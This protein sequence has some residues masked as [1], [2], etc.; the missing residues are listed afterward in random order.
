MERKA[1]IPRGVAPGWS[2]S[3]QLARQP[4]RRLQ[5]KHGRVMVDSNSQLSSSGSWAST[6]PDLEAEIAQAEADPSRHLGRYRLLSV[7]GQGG[8]GVVHRAWDPTLHRLVAIKHMLIGQSADP[9]GVSR[10]L[11]EARASGRLSH[12]SIVS[13]LG[14]GEHRGE[15]FI[16]M[17][18]LE[19][20]PLGH[21]RHAGQC[22]GVLCR[23]VGR[24]AWW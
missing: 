2:P 16:V 21:L 24:P 12:P 17:E 20:Q 7:L 23:L 13:I 9:V 19:G 1:N 18:L 11:R 15:P 22:A 4:L 8:M 14:L 5:V 3:R 6:P 10:F